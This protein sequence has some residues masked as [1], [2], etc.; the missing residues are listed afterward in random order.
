MSKASDLKSKDS[1]FHPDK[2][3]VERARIKNYDN[4]YEESIRNREDFWARE[5][6]DLFWYKKWDKVLDD[7]KKPFY[8]WF[9][10]GKTNV[11]ANA[12]DRHL[13]S[14]TK[15]KLALIWEGEPGDV[16][17]LSYFALNREVSKF[18]NVLK[19]MGAK[20]GDIVTIYMPQIPEIII[21]MLACAKI[22]AAHSVVYGI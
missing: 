10:G 22:G 6:Q 17:T 4:L 12:I 9:T 8:K 18:A 13:D 5:A 3:V 2:S 14:E 11:V 7:S 15:N 19:A 1:V 16:K 20:K 21:A